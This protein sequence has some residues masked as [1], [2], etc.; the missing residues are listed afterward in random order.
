[1]SEEETDLLPFAWQSDDRV[2]KEIARRVGRPPRGT[3]FLRLLGAGVKPPA[4]LTKEDLMSRIFEQQARIIRDGEVRWAHVVQANSLLFAAGKED[5]GAQVIYAP[6]GDVSLRDLGKIAH[7][8]FELK[9]TTPDDPAELKLANMLTDEY[10]R[11][12]DW[13]VPMS[14][15]DGRHV[16]TTIVIVPREHMPGGFLAVSCFPIFADPR[17]RMATLVPA[18]Y[19]PAEMRDDWQKC[20]NLV[21]PQKHQDYYA[22]KRSDEHAAG[23][24]EFTRAVEL[25]PAAAAR[26]RDILIEQGI[27]Y[28]RLHVRA[29]VGLDGVVTQDLRFTN[30]KP[31]PKRQFTYECQGIP[32]VI[33]REHVGQLRGTLIDFRGEGREAQFVFERVEE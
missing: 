30:N 31:D 4:W 29:K 3:D 26:I 19:W 8:A 13:D 22:E 7:R 17:T 20:A 25:T 32:V 12:L 10:E 5:T 21:V 11:A 9:G 33:D 28:G 18:R 6:A 24:M 1:M 15:T 16:V 27:K 14:L 2:P 23:K